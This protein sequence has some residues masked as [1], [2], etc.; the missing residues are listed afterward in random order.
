MRRAPVTTKR[1]LGSC[2]QRCSGGT[3]V[4]GWPLYTS[5]SPPGQDGVILNS[6]G[7]NTWAGLLQGATRSGTARAVGDGR[8][9]KISTWEGA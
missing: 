9:S 1:E 8:G 7:V 2:P 6:W 3:S 4:Y 5:V